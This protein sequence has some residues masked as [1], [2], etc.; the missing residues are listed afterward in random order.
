MVDWFK[1][2]LLK[3]KLLFRSKKKMARDDVNSCKGN[4]EKLARLSNGGGLPYEKE[5]AAEY[6]RLGEVAFSKW[7]NLLMPLLFVL[8]GA[9]AWQAARGADWRHDYYAW[10]NVAGLA[11][12][13][14]AMFW[15][16]W[17]KLVVH[18]SEEEYEKARRWLHCMGEEDH[19]PMGLAKKLVIALGLGLEAW[20]IGVVIA[21]AATSGAISEKWA[22]F[23]GLAI[24]AGIAVLMAWMSHHAGSQLYRAKMRR[25]VDKTIT[26][27]E[28][29]EGESFV[30]K[31][32]NAQNP[33]FL[34]SFTD[35]ITFMQKG[36]WLVA[37]ILV[38][39]LIGGAA[40]YERY[41]LNWETVFVEEGAG[42]V[43]VAP[44]GMIPDAVAQQQQQA[45]MALDMQAKEHEM[46]SI[47]AALAILFLLLLGMNALGILFG[48]QHSFA[49]KR[50]QESWRKIQAYDRMKLQ[51]EKQLKE[52]MAGWAM[53]IADADRWFARYHAILLRCADG[54]C[55]AQDVADAL[56]KRGSYRMEWYIKENKKKE[57][58]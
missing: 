28:N 54:P 29:D 13:L 3:L 4:K 22:G 47:I 39:V 16:S 24:G 40:F 26:R 56:N 41:N 2:Y 32:L 31:E 1:F 45:D 34:A 6:Y 20:A 46:N 5:V 36:G 37:A 8:L 23:A 33:Q 51:G 55:N 21:A 38:S 25:V 27:Q 53:V 35:E 48:Y 57:A 52:E 43:A 9:M 50:S 42:D 10:G 30:K 44:P 14:G 15:V 19:V 12:V 11:A 17:R 7:L 58:S 18:V 49:D